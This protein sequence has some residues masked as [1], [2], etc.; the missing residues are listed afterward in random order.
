[1]RLISREKKTDLVKTLLNQ[2]PTTNPWLKVIYNFKIY[3]LDPIPHYFYFWMIFIARKKSKC[4]SWIY[5]QDL[6]FYPSLQIKKRTKVYVILHKIVVCNK[7]WYFGSLI[8]YFGLVWWE[9]KYNKYIIKSFTQDNN[10]KFYNTTRTSDHFILMSLAMPQ[11]LIAYNNRMLP[12]KTLQQKVFMKVGLMS[13][14]FTIHST[15]LNCLLLGFLLGFF[16]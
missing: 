7:F 11:E 1:M 3:C 12:L 5:P 10:I 14:F 8:I 6:F 16:V 4:D 9:I 15:T 2:I 13:V